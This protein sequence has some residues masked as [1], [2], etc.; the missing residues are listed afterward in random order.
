MLLEENKRRMKQKRFK[1]E[2]AQ[3]DVW[4][5]CYLGYLKFSFAVPYLRTKGDLA[6]DGPPESSRAIQ[7]MPVEHP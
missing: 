3:R 1:E 6:G 2:L 7:I 4:S 5:F